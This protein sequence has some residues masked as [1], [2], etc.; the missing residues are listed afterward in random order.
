[1]KCLKPLWPLPALLFPL[2]AQATDPPPPPN[3]D[4]TPI[5]EPYQEFDKRLNPHIS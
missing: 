5:R 2:L 4:G 1:M 3:P